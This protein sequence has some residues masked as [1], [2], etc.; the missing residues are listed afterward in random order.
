MHEFWRLLIGSLLIVK[1]DHL[2]VHDLSKHIFLSD[3][4]KIIRL[5]VVHRRRIYHLPTGEKFA[6]A[7]LLR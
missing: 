3:Y 7:A 6:A 1:I 5:F 2:R 4:L